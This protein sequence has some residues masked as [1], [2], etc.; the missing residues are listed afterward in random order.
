[1]IEPNHLKAFQ[2]LQPGC[3]QRY[4][5]FLPP[6][7]HEPTCSPESLPALGLAHSSLTF[8]FFHHS[9]PLPL[10]SL[11]KMFL[12]Q[13]QRNH[14]FFYSFFFFSFLN[15]HFNQPGIVVPEDCALFIQSMPSSRDRKAGEGDSA[16]LLLCSSVS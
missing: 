7:D 15:D 14:H 2:S 11:V 16:A 9:N 12:A 6:V 13:E 10:S 5:S 4:N 1:M 3:L 8:I